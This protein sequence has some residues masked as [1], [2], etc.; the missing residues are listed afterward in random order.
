MS[1]L[2]AV[3]MCEAQSRWSLVRILP[4]LVQGP[5]LGTCRSQF[6]LA[7]QPGFW[8]LIGTSLSTDGPPHI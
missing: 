2:R 3:E 8:R 1:E 5:P 7:D 6:R 4:G